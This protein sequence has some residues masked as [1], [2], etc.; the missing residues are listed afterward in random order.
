MAKKKELGDMS[1]NSMSFAVPSMEELMKSPLAN[2]ITFSAND[3]GYGGSAQD[4]FV[5][6]VHPLLLKAK[7]ASVKKIIHLGGKPCMAPLQTNTK[8]LLSLRLKLRNHECF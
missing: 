6:W 8:K 1:M 3:F 7:A 2:F 4:L 5:N